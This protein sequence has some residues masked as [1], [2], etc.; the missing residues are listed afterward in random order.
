MDNGKL[1]SGYQVRDIIQL[2]WSPE[3]FQQWL[4]AV[5][6]PKF[7]KYKSFWRNIG[8][9]LEEGLYRTA[10]L[11]GKIITFADRTLTAITTILE[12]EWFWYVVWIIVALTVISLLFK[13]GVGKVITGLIRSHQGYQPLP[14]Q[15]P[16]KHESEQ[17]DPNH[18]V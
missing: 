16:S 15:S 5:E 2:N 1:A 3:R 12:G 8:R 10:K 18:V 14:V 13:F 4:Q 7:L 6:D 11:P 9:S 17:H